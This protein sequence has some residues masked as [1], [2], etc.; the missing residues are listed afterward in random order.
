EPLAHGPTDS[1]TDATARLR[2]TAFWRFSDRP[3]LVNAVAGRGACRVTFSPD[4]RHILLTGFDPTPV[5]DAATLKPVSPPL[6]HSRPRTPV[7]P[8]LTPRAPPSP[9]SSSPDGGWVLP[10][11]FTAAQ[12]WEA[13][14]A[15]PV[16]GPLQHPDRVLGAAFR[17][18]GRTA[19]TAAKDGL[20]VWELPS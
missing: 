16:T 2:L 20:R 5:W 14:T 6:K 15:R 13:G 19:V 8:R 7:R 18:D 12:V 9:A 10:T 3:A 11:T 4:G 1:D 17:P